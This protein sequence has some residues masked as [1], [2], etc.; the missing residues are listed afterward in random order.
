M[1][2]ESQEDSA[3]APT[4]NHRPGAALAPSPAP[5][6]EVRLH[7]VDSISD[8]HGGGLRRPY[9]A[10]EARPWDELLGTLPPSLCAPAGQGPACGRAGLL[11]L[12]ALL[13]LTC[14]A[15]SI[16]A[17]YLSVLQSESLRVLAHTLRVQEET[18]LKLRLAS[19]AQLRR[20]NASLARAPS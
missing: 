8:L 1:P 13:V 18:L 6:E 20:L 2:E 16:L 9:L 11:L 15:L 5:E 4:Q 3:V 12:L 19:L 10:E 17:V 14:L 7:H